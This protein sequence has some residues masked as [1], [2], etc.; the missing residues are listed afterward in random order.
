MQPNATSTRHTGCH[1]ISSLIREGGDYGIHPD[2]TLKIICDIGIAPY[3]IDYCT[4]N[5][6]RISYE[7]VKFFESVQVKDQ[8]ID[9]DEDG[10]KE[11]YGSSKN[12]QFIDTCLA[13]DQFEIPLESFIGWEIDEFSNISSDAKI[14]ETKDCDQEIVNRFIPAG[15]YVKNLAEYPYGYVKLS[16]KFGNPLTSIKLPEPR[17]YEENSEFV[18]LG[19]YI[20]DEYWDG[21]EYIG[22]PGDTFILPLDENGKV[23]EDIKIYSSWR[24]IEYTVEFNGNGATRGSMDSVS[25]GIKDPIYLPA[26]QFERI[27]TVVFD[28][29]G[30]NVNPTSATATYKFTGWNTKPDG[31]GWAYSDEEFFFQTRGSTSIHPDD[32]EQQE[33]HQRS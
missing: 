16:M 10:E 6:E 13:W 5:G 25:T 1:Y 31:S 22:M 11:Y 26:N 24:Q 18:F 14:G 29:N 7:M 15:Y 32:Q 23:R 27:N 9:A 30:G 28:A 17:T 19:W 8:Y 2:Q 12:I 4:E 20:Y 3:F 21:G 33:S